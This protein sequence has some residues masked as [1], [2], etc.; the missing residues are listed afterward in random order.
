[1]LLL[2]DDAH[3]ADSA[4]SWA[5][6]TVRRFPDAGILL[7][8]AVGTDPDL[9]SAS[10]SRVVAELATLPRFEQHSLSPWTAGDIEDIVFPAMRTATP[11]VRFSY[12]LARITGG[13]PALV[14]AYVSEIESL[15]GAGQLAIVTGARRLIDLRPPL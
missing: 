12:E 11:S 5:C 1:W 14:R 6:D 3:S 10:D 7:L 8:V 4:V 15:P 2:L 13:N 9:P